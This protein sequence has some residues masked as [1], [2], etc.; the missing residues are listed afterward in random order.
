[1]SCFWCKTSSKYVI[2]PFFTNFTIMFAVEKYDFSV[3]VINLI[4]WNE[5]AFYIIKLHTMN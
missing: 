3:T 2:L 5:K 1:M 4:N